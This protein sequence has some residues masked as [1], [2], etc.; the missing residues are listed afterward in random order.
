MFELGLVMFLQSLHHSKL[1][2]SSV[3]ELKVSLNECKLKKKYSKQDVAK[4]KNVMPHVRSTV[5]YLINRYSNGVFVSIVDK[6]NLIKKPY[7][8]IK[9]RFCY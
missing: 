7:I 9:K 3:K 2:P 6:E 1:Y 5:I 4:F 8:T